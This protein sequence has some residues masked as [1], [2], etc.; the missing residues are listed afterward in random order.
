MAEPVLLSWSG[1]KDS[2]MALYEIQKQGQYKMAALLAVMS[3][4]YG[5]VSHHGV[6]GELLEQQAISLGLSLEQVFLSETASIEGYGSKMSHIL[7]KYKS[8]GIESVVFGDIFLEDLR[9]YRESIL[10]E[11]G[12]KGIFP[13]GKEDTSALVRLF[14]D[15]GFKAVLPCIDP[16][17]LAPDFAGRTIDQEFLADLPVAVDPCGE[18][19]EFHSFVFDGPIFKEKIEH[20]VGE[21]VWRPS[22]NYFCDMIS[23]QDAIKP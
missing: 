2:L 6:R 17:K 14:I 1:G 12:M 13:L 5:R 20:R 4:T 23:L 16:K 3:E 9:Q 21:V 22:G 19:G 10:A 18:N 7:A 15:L 8:Q 11:V